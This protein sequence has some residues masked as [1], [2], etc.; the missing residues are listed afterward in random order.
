MSIRYNNMLSG[1]STGA[2]LSNR[3][4]FY[5]ERASIL[6]LVAVSLSIALAN[7]DLNNTENWAP[8]FRV[9]SPECSRYLC[10]LWLYNLSLVCCK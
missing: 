9:V 6:S 5:S 3:L 2:I 8:I 10:I 4:A 7:S 1:E